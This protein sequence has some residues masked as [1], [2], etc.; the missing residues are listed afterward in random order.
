MHDVAQLRE[1]PSSLFDLALGHALAAWRQAAGQ[2]QIALA[3]QIGVC[4]S[5]LSRWEMGQ[6]G[7]PPSILARFGAYYGTGTDAIIADVGAILTRVL[8]QVQK[9]YTADIGTYADLQ[10][11][12]PER[13]LAN[14]LHYHAGVVARRRWQRTVTVALAAD[15]PAVTTEPAEPAPPATVHADVGAHE[16]PADASASVDSEP[17]PDAPGKIVYDP[18][19]GDTPPAPITFSDPFFPSDEGPVR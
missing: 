11:G 9:D 15:P 6:N 7:P 4:Q 1:I 12:V 3:A 19:V 10:K 17:A 16:T 14:L 2:R 18:F 8:E 13:D 5:S